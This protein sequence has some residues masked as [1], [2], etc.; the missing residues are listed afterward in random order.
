MFDYI[1]VLR[2]LLLGGLVDDN[3]DVW[4][5]L[6]STDEGDWCILVWSDCGTM[7]LATMLVSSTAISATSLGC[8]L[9]LRCKHRDGPWN[10]GA[11]CHCC[12]LLSKSWVCVAGCH[13]CKLLHHQSMF[14]VACIYAHYGLTMARPRLWLRAVACG[15][16]SFSSHFSSSNLVVQ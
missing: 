10:K 6:I 5:E 16:H 1:G 14:F 11:L 15:S 13:H 7:A 4:D 12:Q 9:M 2:I 8:P 3:W